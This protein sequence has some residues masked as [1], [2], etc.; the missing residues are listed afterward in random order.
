MVD[1]YSDVR[2]IT[3]ALLVFELRYFKSRFRF[4]ATPCI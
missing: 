4:F 2:E 3:I 1:Q